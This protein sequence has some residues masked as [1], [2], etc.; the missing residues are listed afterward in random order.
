[1]ETLF[2]NKTAMVFQN[3]CLFKNK[4]V[5]ENIMM[6]LFW[7]RRKRERLRWRLC[8]SYWNR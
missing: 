8:Y 2:G 5:L 6:P 1:M 4:T 3:Y 7:F